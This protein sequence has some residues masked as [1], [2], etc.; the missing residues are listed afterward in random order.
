MTAYSVTMHILKCPPEPIFLIPIRS[1]LGTFLK[2]LI[3]NDV[4]V[5][6]ADIFEQLRLHL[7]SFWT[8]VAAL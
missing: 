4:M 3:V 7:L 5:L 8:L 6:A 1:S 2:E